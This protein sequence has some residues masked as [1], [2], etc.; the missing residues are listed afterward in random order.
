MKKTKTHLFEYYYVHRCD[1][2]FYI[3]YFIVNKNNFVEY[4]IARDYICRCVNYKKI[5]HVND[6]SRV[7]FDDKFESQL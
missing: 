1:R 5:I 4:I 2:Q 3:F 7:D 6:V